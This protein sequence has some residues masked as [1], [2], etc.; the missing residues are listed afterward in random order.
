MLAKVR[1]K[2]Q[3]TEHYL[4]IARENFGDDWTKPKPLA[5]VFEALTAKPDGQVYSMEPWYLA[6]YEPQMEKTAI[7]SLNREGFE[8]WYPTF[9]DVRQLALRKIPP[10]KR[11]QAGLYIE[12]VRRPRFAGYILIRRLFGYFDVNR[13]FDLKGCGSVVKLGGCPAKVIDY[14][15]ELMRLAEADGIYDAHELH[16]KHKG[17]KVTQLQE[18]E[19]K[20][21]VG[22]SKALGR[23]DE[24]GR[25]S[26]MVDAF[27]RVAHLIASADPAT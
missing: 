5:L 21:W 13:L 10:K 7:D 19:S 9:K 18:T 24:S 12:E 8:C 14:D 22:Q 16:I 23:L 6:R 26:L 15:V 1:T 20:R 11:H 2:A 25:T 27:G 3:A 4:N 17:Y